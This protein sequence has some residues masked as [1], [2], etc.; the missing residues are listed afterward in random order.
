MPFSGHTYMFFSKLQTISKLPALKH[1]I[2]I[3][4]M[5]L[6]ILNKSGNATPELF[7]IYIQNDASQ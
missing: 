5:Q 2:N 3:Q 1:Q 6:Y 7:A 4:C